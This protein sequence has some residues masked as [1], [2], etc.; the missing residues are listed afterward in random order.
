MTIMDEETMV[1]PECG[2]VLNDPEMPLSK[3]R[4]AFNSKG[5]VQIIPITFDQYLNRKEKR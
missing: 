3:T 2:A 5:I 4:C 1:C